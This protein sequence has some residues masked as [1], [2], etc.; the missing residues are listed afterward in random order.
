M[1]TV[2]MQSFIEAAKQKSL[3][4]AAKENN[5]SQPALSKHIRNLENELDVAL[6]YRTST[7][8][9]LTEAGERFRS[10]ILPVITELNAIRQDLRQFSRTSPIAIGSLPSLATYYLPPMIKKLQ[11]LAQPAT[12][13]IQNTSN[14]LVQS[15]EE[16]RLDAIF[17]DTVST[18]ES[19]WSCELFKEPYYAVF[20]LDHPYRSR[21]A[22]KLAELCEEQLIVHQSPCDTRSR[23]MEHM[24]LIGQKPTIISEVAFGDFIYGAVIAGMG[25]T[26][27]P[28]ISAEHIDRHQLFA[29]PIIDFG[30]ERSISLATRNAKLGSQLY[31]YFC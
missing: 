28:E 2:W 25:I 12:L 5:I 19:L 18:R 30:N 31:Q 3:S 29:L 14:E 1:N 15:L 13:M 27:V 9:E 20:P 23:I 6:F 8:I 11:S 16:G 24:E 22:V 7:G 10:R 17:M 26:I 4:K 21:K